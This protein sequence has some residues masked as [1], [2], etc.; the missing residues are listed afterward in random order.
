MRTASAIEVLPYWL[1]FLIPAW[2]VLVPGRLKSSQAWLPWIAVLVLFSM[3]IGLRHEVGGDW[4]SYLPQFLDAG[5]LPFSEV[6]KGGDPGYYVVN[7]VVW[8]L[9]GSI[10][11]VNLVCAFVLMGGT[12]V[13][14]RSQPRPWLAML[15]AVPYMLVVVAMGYTRQAVAL[16]FA[17]FALNAL[18]N[19]RVRWF[20]VW[21]AFGATFHKSAVLLLP[22]AALA[23]SR[24]RFL[25]LVLVGITTALLYYLLL[26]ESREVLWANYIE[27]QSESEGGLI[28]VLM[29][30]V[31]AL[32]L[33]VFADRLVPELQARR[34]WLWLSA[35]ALLCI[36]LVPFASTAVDRVAL[37]LIPIQLFVVSRLPALAPSSQGRTVLVAGVV[38]YY[39]AVLFVWLNYASHAHVWVPYRFMPWQ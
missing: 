22:I 11:Q 5:A 33:M 30:A 21:I 38:I 6:L 2:A 17:L 23:A 20:V 37:Y 19:G 28:R 4:F 26:A 27:A 39:A 25:T 3:L 18:G 35:F 14:C 32:L 36:P 24:H 13:F 31:P 12:V 34:L 29:N 7:W 1:M 9:G 15:A 16:G 8:H 10:Y